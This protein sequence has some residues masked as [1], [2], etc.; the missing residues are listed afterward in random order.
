M[1]YI[2]QKAKDKLFNELE[3]QLPLYIGTPGE[4][5]FLMTELCKVY[6]ANNKLNYQTINDIVGAL[7][8]C[9]LEFYRRVGAPYEDLKINQ[10]GDVY[11]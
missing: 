7:E 11:L 5:N 6:V 9:K 2:D 8:G 4:L 10:N 1:P 3:T